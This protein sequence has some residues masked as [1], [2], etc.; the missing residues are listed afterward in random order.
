MIRGRHLDL[1]GVIIDGTLGFY[2]ATF[3]GGTVS[4]GSV[5]FEGWNRRS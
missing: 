1:T 4:F 2:G 5:A 3:P